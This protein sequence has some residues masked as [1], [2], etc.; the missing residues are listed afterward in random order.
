MSAFGRRGGLG[1]LDLFE[2]LL[3][4]VLV[5]AGDLAV[6][7]RESIELLLGQVFDVDHLVAGG[8]NAQDELIQFQVDGL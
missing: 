7:F 8:S 2:A 3:K 5:R 4:L 6:A 1:L